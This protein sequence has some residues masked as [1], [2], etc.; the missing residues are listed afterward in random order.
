M[1]QATDT[2]G[3]AASPLPATLAGFRNRHRGRTIVVCGCGPSLNDFTEP[4]RFITIGVND[5]GRR[6]DPTYLVVVDPPSRFSAD[7]FRHVAESRARAIF[8]PCDLG[9]THPHI[10]RFGLGRKGGVNFDR[11]DVVDYTS[12]SPYVAALI[13]IRMGAS[14][15][16]L[17]GVDFSDHHFFGATGRH[18]L[19]RQLPRIDEEYR[20]LAAAAASRGVEIVNLSTSSRLTSLPRVSLTSFD[21]PPPAAD[22]IAAPASKPRVF[23]VHYQFVAC[24]D[25]FTAGLNRAADELNLTH[26]AASCDDLR[27][28]HQIAAFGPDLVFVVQGRIAVNRWSRQLRRYNTAV[29]L[30]DEPYEVDDSS[31]WSTV[32]KTVFVNDAAACARHRG[33]TYL[34]TC[35]DPFRHYDAASPRPHDVGFIGAPSRTRERTLA[36]L[37]P[38]GLLTYIVGAGWRHPILRQLTRSN[39]VSAAEAADLYRQTKI[40]VNVF[41]DRHH[42]N[43]TRLVGVSMNPRVYEALA[44]GALVVSE[45]RP[46]IVERLPELPTFRNE[47]ELVET[48]RRL[49][50]NP[51]ELT[52][53]VAACRARIAGDHYT[54]RLSRVLE[55]AVRTSAGARD[56]IRIQNHR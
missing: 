29:W 42:F 44:C 14:R 22:A 49:L 5:V 26:A 20:R 9:I 27:L 56:S 13:A 33:A 32:F 21:E 18:P 40:V 45:P 4:D 48:V 37:A 12:N 11:D 51:A 47:V 41:R 36:A 24:G 50:A 30:L 7:R 16:A 10:V 23:F 54:A 46:E 2:G 15:V 25:V 31:R 6:F 39:I 34:P 1:D 38:H 17:A 8:T 19:A 53:R 3:T 43:K 55:V 28:P 52:E 35:F